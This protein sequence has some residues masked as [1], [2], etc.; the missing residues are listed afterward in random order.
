MANTCIG[1]LFLND[2]IENS[3]INCKDNL[4]YSITR[5]LGIQIT[6]H[7]FIL[8]AKEPSKLEKYC[9]NETTSTYT[10]ESAYIVSKTEYVKIFGNCY[11]H[12]ENCGIF[13]PPQEIK[14]KE[15]EVQ[16]VRKNNFTDHLDFAFNPQKVDSILKEKTALQKVQDD[17]TSMHLNRGLE[18]N[19]QI[20]LPV[21][22]T[23]GC[24]T[25]LSFIALLC[26]CIYIKKTM[27]SANVY[28]GIN[29][30]PNVGQGAALQGN[31]S[32]S[33]RFHH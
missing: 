26:M 1:S 27:N 32:F 21:M 5:N 8:I 31:Q 7:D 33:S 25:I 11:C 29:L 30:G 10:L 22:I 16:F 28:S 6:N 13:S 12:F 15:E 17:I 14:G 4:K 9:F 23:L 20:S 2:A 3:E 18:K 24:F 19:D